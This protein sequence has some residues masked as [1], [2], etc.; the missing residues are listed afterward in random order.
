MQVIKYVAYIKDVFKSM[1]YFLLNT[2]DTYSALG[3]SVNK[4]KKEK[5]LPQQ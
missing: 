3:I 4:K 5:K 1:A 2:A